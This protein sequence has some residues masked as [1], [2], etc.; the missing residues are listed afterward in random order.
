MQPVD[1]AVRAFAPLDDESVIFSPVEKIGRGDFGRVLVFDTETTIDRFQNLK[2]GSFKVYQYGK[3]VREGVFYKPESVSKSE[4]EVLAAYCKEHK[5]KLMTVREFVDTIF[6]PEVYDVKT[7]C[8]GFNLP[9]DLS[10]IAKSFGFARASMKGGFSFKLTES[11]RRPRITIKHLDNSKSFIHFGN[12]V[13][14]NNRILD[15]KGH[16]LDLRTLVHAL[17]TESH[18]LESACKILGAGIGKAQVKE[19]GKITAE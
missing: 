1:I 9:F 7:L 18:S 11:K 17:T 19:H 15:F 2:F 10:R 16:F 12:S 8:V 4:Q 5:I 3:P 13:D 14:I 6:L